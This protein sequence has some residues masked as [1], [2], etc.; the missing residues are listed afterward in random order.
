MSRGSMEQGKK[1]ANVG[2]RAEKVR[3]IEGQSMVLAS[4]DS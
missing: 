1:Y 2:T 4:Q 3:S